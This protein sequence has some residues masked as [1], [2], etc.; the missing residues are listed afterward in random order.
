EQLH[1]QLYNLMGQKVEAAVQEEG[2]RYRFSSGH[3]PKG[4]YL[5]RVVGREGRAS[6]RLVKE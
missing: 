6:F 4:V 5:L 2:N 1:F 3:L